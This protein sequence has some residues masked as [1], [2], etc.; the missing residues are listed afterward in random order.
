MSEEEAV[1]FDSKVYLGS[2]DIGRVWVASGKVCFTPATTC[3]GLSAK[4]L[5]TITAEVE[6][7]TAER[8]A[9]S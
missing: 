3:P 1:V 2:R 7:K 4:Q 9:S 5:K 8:K 6:R